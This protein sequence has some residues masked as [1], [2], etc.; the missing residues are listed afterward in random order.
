MSGS[1]RRVLLIVGAVAIAAAGIAL[2][3]GELDGSGEST[4]DVPAGPGAATA[5]PGGALGATLRLGNV[6]LG[7]RD[8]ADGPAARAWTLAHGGSPTPAIVASGQAVIAKG[9]TQT[10]RYVILAWQ[11]AQPAT[12]LSDPALAAFLDAWLGRGAE[13]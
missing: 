7:Y 13:G 3:V 2:L 5:T 6:V 1:L 10:A 11:R 9:R 4:T 8:A 12:T